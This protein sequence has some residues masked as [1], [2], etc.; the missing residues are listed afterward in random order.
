MHKF[1]FIVIIFFLRFPLSAQVANLE[2]NGILLASEQCT[3]SINLGTGIA[4]WYFGGGISRDSIVRMRLSEG[5]ALRPYEVDDVLEISF[6]KEGM[7]SILKVLHF[8]RNFNKYRW[9]LACCYYDAGER[10][11]N[12]TVQAKEMLSIWF[13]INADGALQVTQ[14]LSPIPHRSIVFNPHPPKK[15][16]V[17][18]INS[19]LTKYATVRPAVWNNQNVQA[20]DVLWIYC[21][22][23]YEK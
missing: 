12:S 7:K 5:A 19:T 2:G 9:K 20:M 11:P 8:S 10:H 15:L 22:S 17:E 21:P 6:S 16:D 23:K 1:L 4:G 3:N 14:L 13:V 18:L